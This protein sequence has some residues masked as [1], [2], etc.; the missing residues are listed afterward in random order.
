MDKDKQEYRINYLE[1]KA[2]F[3]GLQSLCGNITQK[4]VCILSDN[5]TTFAYI[6]AMGGVKSQGC[7]EMALQCAQDGESRGLD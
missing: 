6:N 3:L 1:M 7:N 2:V 5:T 4:H